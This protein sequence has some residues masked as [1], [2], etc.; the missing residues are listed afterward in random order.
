LKRRAKVLKQALPSQPLNHCIREAI[1]IDGLLGMEK[2][3]RQDRITVGTVRV[4]GDLLGMG[5]VL[6]QDQ[7]K[8]L[9]ENLLW[10]D[11]HSLDRVIAGDPHRTV[12]QAQ[13]H[14]ASTLHLRGQTDDLHW[15]VR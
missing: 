5:K 9:V 10:M 4:I 1:I 3:Y 7:T 15:M 11:T 8:V 12:R 14:Y 6:H 13:Y 2:V